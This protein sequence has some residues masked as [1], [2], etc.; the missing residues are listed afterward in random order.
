MK[1]KVVFEKKLLHAL[2]DLQVIS[3][4]KRPSD[5]YPDEV[6]EALC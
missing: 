4:G 3:K 5:V 6:L 1:M 2:G